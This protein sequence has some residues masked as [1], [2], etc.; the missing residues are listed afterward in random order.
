MMKDH[1]EVRATLVKVCDLVGFPKPRPDD[2]ISTWADNSLDGTLHRGS[3]HWQ[4]AQAHVVDALECALI[5]DET[6]TRLSL[7]KARDVA[8]NVPRCNCHLSHLPKRIEAHGKT[9]CVVC[10]GLV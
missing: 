1:L 4:R 10:K 6:G 8:K 3:G 5:G 7:E 9:W 2:G